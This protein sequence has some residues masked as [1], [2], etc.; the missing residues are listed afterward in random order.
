MDRKAGGERIALIAIHG[1]ADQQPGVT[2]RE[3]VDLLTAN[4]PEGVRYTHPCSEAF[5]LRVETL[6]PVREDKE[7]TGGEKKDEPTP[8]GK[9]PVGKAWRQSTRSDFIS[10]GQADAG[11]QQNWSADIAFTDYLLHKAHRN[12]TPVET[13]AGIRHVLEREAAPPSSPRRVDVYEMYWADLSRLSGAIPRI[14]TELF[15]LIFRL[16]L[17]GR[18][19]LGLYA[20]TN[21]E[22]GWAWLAKLQVALDWTLSRCLGPLALALLLTALI[23]APAAWL[24]WTNRFPVAWR[25]LMVILP[26]GVFVVSLYKLSSRASGVVVGACAAALVAALLALSNPGWSVGLFWLAVLSLIHDFIL[27][28]CDERFPMARIAGWGIWGPV[29]C[30]TIV[31]AE[32]KDG[33]DWVRGGLGAFELVLLLTLI[34]WLGM[35]VLLALWLLA[36]IRVGRGDPTGLASKATARLGLLVSVSVFL[37]LTMLVAAALKSVLAGFLAVYDY[38]PWWF[39]RHVPI[40]ANDFLCIRIDHHVQS[41]TGIAI[42]GGVLVL[43][44]ALSFLPSVLA[45]L[46]L[47][48]P[49]AGR[50]GR[51]LTAGY[52]QLE[53]VV[54]VLSG[55]GVVLAVAV[56]CFMV[57]DVTQPD[58]T[59]EVRRVLADYGWTDV[60]PGILYAM[61]GATLSI[62]VLGGVLSRFLPGLRAPLDAAL[63]VDN[64]LR[65]FP[66]RAIPRAR[67]FSRYV[68]LLE[69]VA[70]EKYDRI[71]I[72]A[73]SQGTVISAELLRYLK[74]RGERHG[75]P[76]ERLWQDLHGRLHLLTAGC[77]LRQLYA[78]RFPVIYAWVLGN[79]STCGPNREPLGVER[80]VN[81]YTTGDYV[82]RW[83]WTRKAG[84]GEDWPAHITETPDGQPVCMPQG[85]PPLA[86][87]CR[88][89]VCLGSGAH[90]HYFNVG[91]YRMAAL[92]DGLAQP[93]PYP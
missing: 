67:I 41:F 62:S 10:T 66:R 11:R 37:L 89:D 60:L 26:A 44:L 27:R 50:L 7:K 76:L 39:G 79:G 42:L 45:E 25:I 65:E 15:T 32:G 90:T 58:V 92:I 74:L 8:E 64:H 20:R 75:D 70:A 77:P 2:A 56:A 13:Y 73:H 88:K 87:G 82:G 43:Y 33:A 1:V 83:L 29:L 71:L 19:T 53:R 57:L 28:I 3:I 54:A 68:A 59:A 31:L 55:L 36:L 34:V 16:S 72:V 91:Q 86:A 80:W 18:D 14:L 22:G 35:A 52:R 51:W 63:D 21:P 85:L 48:R 30:L 78:A 46:K 93:V 4:A 49:D 69:H 84:T 6:P 9:R 24:G 38:E 5:T 17:L 61:A 12:G 47:A 23:F 40:A 81:A